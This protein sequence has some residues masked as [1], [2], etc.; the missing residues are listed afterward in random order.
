LGTLKEAHPQEDQDHA[1]ETKMAQVTFGLFDWIDR[2]KAPLHQLY[3]ERL[4]L[5]E[6]ADAA[7]FSGY[8]LAE[9][10]ATPLGMAPSPALFLTA[11][12]QRTRRIRLGPLVYLLPLYHPLRLI[13]EVCML[14]NL[15]GGRLDLGVGR[16]VSPYELGYFGVDAAKS[17]AIFN[18]ALAILIAGLTQ[19]RLTFEGEHYQ[20]HDVPM[21]LQPLQQP[22]PP[23]WYPTNNPESVMYAARH[24]YH[25]VSLGPAAGVRQLVDIYWQTWKVH[26]QAPD[27]LNGHVAAPKVGVVRQV[28]VA[29]TDAEALAT[30][31]AAHRDWY[32]SITKLW[33]DHDDHMPDNL[34][35]WETSTQH[36]TILFGSPTRVR[37]QM[38]ELLEVSGCNYVIGAFAWGTFPHEQTLHSLRLFAEEVMPAFAGSAAP[39]A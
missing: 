18:E 16:G 39:L 1:E 33:H 27:R 31:R 10:H 7:G 15:S 35:S 29:D 38:A 14:D 6:A 36:E 11:A 8:H 34:F 32:R 12:A 4:Q 25:F 21:E 23:L 13:E 37:E 2:G 5:L 20:Y 9:H 26:R 24:G 3:E 17:R 22:Y 28:F 30:T 19:A